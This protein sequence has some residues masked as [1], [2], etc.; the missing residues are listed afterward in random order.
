[1]KK[2]LLSIITMLFFATTPVF[3]KII[4]V[5]AVTDFS[6]ANPPKTWQV[7][8][9]ESFV[10]KNHYYVAAGSIFE[11]KIS[12]VKAPQRLKRNAVFTFVPTRFYDA[13]KQEIYEIKNHYEG[14][15]TTK[16]DLSAKNIAKK[17]A[18]TVGN[19]FFDSLVGPG[20]AL[21]EGAVKNETGNRAKSAALA[22]YDAT[23]LSYAKK[24][25]EIE[26]SK[27]QVFFMNFETVEEDT[28]N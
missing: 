25:Q 13:N 21:V 17:S 22:A 12:K 8:V 20:V 3:A 1:M 24:G 6:T 14:K 28:E 11:G 4:K 10:A 7:K 19:H 23:P 16:P 5:E 18:I 2:L 26:I 27:G 15:Y 9:V